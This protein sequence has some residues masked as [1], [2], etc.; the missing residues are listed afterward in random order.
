MA[1]G[2][3]DGVAGEYG[4][5]GGGSKNNANGDTGRSPAVSTTL[6]PVSSA[7]WAEANR[8]RPRPVRDV[9]GGQANT[10]HGQGSF[11]AGMGSNANDNGDFVWSDDPSGGGVTPITVTG[12]NQFLGA[13]ARRRDVLFVGEFG[14]RREPRAGFGNVVEPERPEREERHRA[15]ERR[16][17]LGAGGDAADQRM[18][19]HDRTRRA[20]RRP[21]GA[22]LLRGVQRRRRRPAHHVH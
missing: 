15:G 16:R 17:H 3:E 13:R 2:Y 14:E 19:L 22:G 7:P 18:E 4:F 21:D 9:P 8:T 20:S 1:G 10:A 6:P 11:A 12:N 5:V